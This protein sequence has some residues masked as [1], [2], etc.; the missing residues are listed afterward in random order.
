MGICQAAVAAVCIGLWALLTRR[1]PPVS[2]FVTFFLCGSLIDV[3][4]WTDFAGHLGLG[5]YALLLLGSALCA[6]ASSLIIMSG[7]GIRA[8]DLL[9]IGARGR[10]RWPFWCGKGLVEGVL[11]LAGWLLGGP[12]GIGT[13]SF[14]VFVD[15]LIEPFVRFNRRYLALRDHGF[16][17]QAGRS[18]VQAQAVA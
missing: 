9:A 17:A 11:L 7:F 4:R 16:Y 18:R 12:V 3:L 15:L 14:L 10:W 1:R 2:P 8:I 5:P 6:Y 13:V